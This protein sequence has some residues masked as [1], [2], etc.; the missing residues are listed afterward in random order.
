[1][2]RLK[3]LFGLSIISKL[4]IRDHNYLCK[5]AIWGESCA[6]KTAVIAEDAGWSQTTT[7]FDLLLETSKTVTYP[8]ASVSPASCFTITW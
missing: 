8:V 3:P 7:T 6:G 5:I 2:Q 4:M 1:M